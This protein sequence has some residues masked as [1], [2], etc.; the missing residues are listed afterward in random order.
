MRTSQHATKRSGRLQTRGS[1]AGYVRVSRVGERD[2][3]LRSPEFQRRAIEAKAT[4]AGVAVT[5]FKP[6]LDV[7]GAKRA[8]AVLD[9]IVAKIEA[10]E[11][12]G[13]I[14]YN[15]SRLSR[16]RPM[17][18]IELVE[19]IE[20]AGGT[21]LSASESFD[22]ATPEGRF[23]RDLFFAIARMDWERAADGF[24][25]AKENAIASGIAIMSLAPFGYR[26]NERHGLEVVAREARVVREIFEMRRSGLSYGDCLARFEERTGRSSNRSTMRNM[27]R[28]RA[29]LGELHYGQKVALSK[30][31]A[32]APIVELELFEAVQAV[33]DARARAHGYKGGGRAKSLLAGIARCEGCGRGLVRTRTGSRREYS[34]KCPNDA[35]HCPARAFI[36][37]EPLETL[38][39]ERVLEWAGPD[40]DELLELEVRLEAADTRAAAERRL[41]DAERVLAG[42]LV[43][44]ELQLADELAY[45]AG[46]RVRQELVEAR[47]QELEEMGEAGDLEVVRGTLRRVLADAEEYEVDERRR[48]LAVALESVVVRRTPRRG[49][50]AV[51]R[52]VVR[53]AGAASMGEE[54]G[55][56]LIA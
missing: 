5:M 36:Q 31:D 45:K 1:F 30:I 24:A 8:R 54:H 13:V 6:E 33:I 50:P 44:V 52:V 17:E 4:A 9:S 29:Y 55:A 19:R 12:A 41:E 27:L 22:A 47:R 56:E 34:Y 37:A 38:V 40:A 23:Q 35:R 53:F 43:D 18:R 32:H 3:R 42:Y 10:G 48:L 21:I 28:N 16:L 15:L 2:D 11:L 14:V 25:V 51:E 20:A 46:A 39:V 26:F 7:S 49:A